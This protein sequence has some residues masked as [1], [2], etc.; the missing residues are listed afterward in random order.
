MNKYTNIILI[1]SPSFYIVETLKLKHTFCKLGYKY[2]THS[3]FT[4]FIYYSSSFESDLF[5]QVYILK[6]LLADTPTN[7]ILYLMP[8]VSKVYY[9]SFAVIVLL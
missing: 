1:Y 3:L 8:F 6:Y 9:P 7:Y 4:I 5:H 2:I